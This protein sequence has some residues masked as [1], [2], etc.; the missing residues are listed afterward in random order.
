MGDFKDLPPDF[1]RQPNAARIGTRQAAIAVLVVD[2]DAPSREQ[3]AAA[4]TG[5]GIEVATAG[6]AAEA[7]RLATGGGPVLVVSEMYL[8]DSTGLDLAHRLRELGARPA[9]IFVSGSLTISRAVE[10]MQLGA[11]TVFEKPVDLQ[12]LITTIITRLRP[13][14]PVQPEVDPLRFK[15][16]HSVA[17]RWAT[18]VWRACRAPEGDFKTLARW[19][20]YLGMSYSSLCETCRLLDIRP[21]DARD[22]AR[23]LHAVVASSCAGCRADVLLDISDRRTLRRMGARA[24]VDLVTGP[25]TAED[26]LRGQQFIPATNQGLLSLHALIASI[27]PSSCGFTG[28]EKAK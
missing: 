8:P 22:F 5:L 24:G 21:Q 2:G 14:V 20:R 10:A 13:A 7:L 16:P 28:C 12:H 6:S 23:I 25:L 4:V 1:A 17:D 11:L 3:I 26:F 27:G 15:C 19:A 18:Y 9:F